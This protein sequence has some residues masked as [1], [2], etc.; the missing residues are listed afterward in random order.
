MRDG[1]LSRNHSNQELRE[2]E[3]MGDVGGGGGGAGGGHGGHS[4]AGLSGLANDN[5][6]QSPTWQPRFMGSKRDQH[7][8]SPGGASTVVGVVSDIDKPLVSGGGGGWGGGGGDSHAGDGDGLGHITGGKNS[9]QKKPRTPPAVKVALATWL[10][11]CSLVVLRVYS[12]AD[13]RVAALANLYY[14]APAIVLM[15]LW[16]WVGMGEGGR[17]ETLISS[18][19][20]FSPWSFPYPPPRPNPR[21]LFFA[22]Y[23]SRRVRSFSSLLPFSP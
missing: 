3:R 15:A 21:F 14:Q 12:A 22:L 9:P 2:R 7:G 6:Y 10:L 13:E 5:N 1:L 4:P 17:G 23:T 16:L 8:V 18:I 20:F 11:A 19:F